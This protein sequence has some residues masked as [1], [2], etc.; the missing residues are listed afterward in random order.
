MLVRECTS[1]KQALN[2][3]WYDSTVS[4]LLVH[5]G[6]TYVAVHKRV[7][8][9][10]LLFVEKNAARV[11]ASAKPEILAKATIPVVAAKAAP[12]KDASSKQ[13]TPAE[14]A[15]GQTA[16]ADADKGQKQPAG[17]TQTATKTAAQ[18]KDKSATTA[19]APTNPAQQVATKPAPQAKPIS[20]VKVAAKTTAAPAAAT[21]AKPQP[22]AKGSIV[23]ASTGGKPT[24]P[25][26]IAEKNQK[27]SRDTV[28]QLPK[29]QAA[30]GRSI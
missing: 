10:H 4:D 6:H 21:A 2:N 5:F 3:D 1:E 18:P 25:A 27:P 14:P 8:T 9:S 13:T 20:T 19:T 22:Q 16:V 17:A 15:K 23:P 28:K 24:N 26:K 11:I 12:T 29:Q 7:K 30:L